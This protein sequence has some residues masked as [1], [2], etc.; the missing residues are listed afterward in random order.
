MD[1]TSARIDRAWGKYAL[2]LLKKS[3]D[4]DEEKKRRR[5]EEASVQEIKIL[6]HI[7]YVLLIF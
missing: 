4:E 3:Q 7:S 6:F 5:N 2:V 1:E